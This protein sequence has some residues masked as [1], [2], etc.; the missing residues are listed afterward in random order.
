MKDVK[1]E[2]E[3]E[4]EFKP[5]VELSRANRIILDNARQKRDGWLYECMSSILISAFQFEGLINQI[6]YIVIPYWEEIERISRKGKLKMICS[7]LQISINPSERP[8]QSIFELFSFRDQLA[9]PKPMILRE[10]KF[11][12]QENIENARRVWPKTKWEKMCSIEFAERCS[13]DIR[14]LGKAL[15]EK[16]QIDWDD[17]IS[18]GC[19]YSI[20]PYIQE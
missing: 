11:C 5:Y 6:G 17:F 3:H 10:K 1:L 13:E 9:H 14:Q 16:S 20:G 15:C 2:I 19:L 4:R 7:V 18:T 8:F 12:K